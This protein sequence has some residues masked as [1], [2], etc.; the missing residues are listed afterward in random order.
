MTGIVSC[1]RFPPHLVRDY[2]QDL[3]FAP[4]IWS[5]IHSAYRDH[6]IEAKL[7]GFRAE[8]VEANAFAHFASSVKL[9]W[10]CNL[11]P[12][13]TAAN[14]VA[15]AARAALAAQGIDDDWPCETAPEA[16]ALRSC[17][18][19]QCNS[20][21]PVQ[22]ARLYTRAH[23][24]ALVARPAHRTYYQHAMLAWRI[25]LVFKTSNLHFAGSRVGAR[26]RMRL[27]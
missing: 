10:E 9:N 21:W 2:L 8:G 14:E 1:C 13:L 11:T 25:L 7:A 4:V 24:F 17:H 12:C 23:P 27:S 20:S 6:L 5:S 22:S 16:I 15:D 3:G 26:S 18:Q 19:K